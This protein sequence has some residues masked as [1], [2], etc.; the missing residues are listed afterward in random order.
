MNG[1]GSWAFLQTAAWAERTCKVASDAAQ[2]ARAVLRASFLLHW[3]I[4]SA[5]PLLRPSPRSLLYDMSALLLDGLAPA[6]R[7]IEKIDALLLFTTPRVT[8][9]VGAASEEAGVQGGCP[10]CV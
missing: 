4:K 5:P 10:G 8:A 9:H 2:L 1:R 3:N 6:L 7:G